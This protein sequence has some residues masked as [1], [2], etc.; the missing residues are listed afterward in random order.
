DCESSICNVVTN[1]CVATDCEDGMRDDA[2]T[3]VDCG[4]AT[5]PKCGEGKACTTPGDCTRLLCNRTSHACVSDQ[6]FDGTEDQSES[7]V[8]CGGPDCNKCPDG[9]HCSGGGDCVAGSICTFDGSCC[10]PNGTACNGLGCGSATDNCGQ[11]FNCGNN[12]ACA[13]SATPNCKG[14]C[15]S[16][17]KDQATTCSGKQ[18]GSIAD[19]CG[20]TYNCGSCPSGYSCSQAPSYQCCPDTAT[21]C[22]GHAGCSQVQVTC[23]GST[24]TVTCP[25]ASGG[26]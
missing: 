1:L 17:Y 26:D 6:C 2:E 13:S 16:A 9:K 18:C 23:N 12:G 21:A 24:V 10:H 4:G 25:C 15:C 8:D 11:T 7:D 20:T 19:G 3:D 14:N 5:C 22:A